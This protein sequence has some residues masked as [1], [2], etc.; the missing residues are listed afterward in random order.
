MA[1]HDPLDVLTS[2]GW[3]VVWVEDFDHRVHLVDDID[4]VLIDPRVERPAA[5]S[6]VLSLLAL[7]DPQTGLHEAS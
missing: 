2:L 7:P 3:R 4:I 6:A 5:A 1:V